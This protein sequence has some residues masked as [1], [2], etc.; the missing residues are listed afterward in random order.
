MSDK[1]WHVEYGPNPF[2]VSG[3]GFLWRLRDEKGWFELW[4]KQKLAWDKALSLARKHQARAILHR[5]D[6]SVRLVR[7][8]VPGEPRAKGP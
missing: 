1:E 4:S 6:G 5:K 3:T 8:W 7:S 2:S